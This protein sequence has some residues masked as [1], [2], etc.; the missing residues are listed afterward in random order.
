MASLEYAVRQPSLE[1]S[2]IWLPIIKE[3]IKMMQENE[4]K[5]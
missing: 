5:S 2:H 1:M 4:S 3:E